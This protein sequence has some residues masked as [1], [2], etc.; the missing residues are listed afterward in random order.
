MFATEVEVIIEDAVCEQRWDLPKTKEMIFKNLTP[1]TADIK[2]VENCYIKILID[3]AR[4]EFEK[5]LVNVI[6]QE[7]KFVEKFTRG[8]DQ[9]STLNDLIGLYK[10]D[11]YM[12]QLELYSNLIDE[13]ELTSLMANLKSYVWKKILDKSEGGNLELNILHNLVVCF[14]TNTASAIHEKLEEFKNNCASQSRTGGYLRKL[15]ENIRIERN[16]NIQLENFL[17][18]IR[19]FKSDLFLLEEQMRQVICF[20]LKPVEIAVRNIGNRSVIEIIGGVIRLSQQLSAI[21][22]KLMNNEH[23]RQNSIGELRFIALHMVEIDCDLENSRWHGFNIFI[24][25]TSVN[26]SKKCQWDLSGLSSQKQLEKA[27]SGNSNSKDGD[28]GIDGHSGESSGNVM[29]VADQMH[30]AEHLTVIVNGG[31]GLNGQ[32]GGD[33]ANGKNGEGISMND[34]KKKFP[35]PVHFWGRCHNLWKV[36]NQIRLMGQPIPSWTKGA[37]CYAELKLENGQEIIHSVSR[38]LAGNCYLLYKGSKGEPGGRGGLN[39][40]GGEGGFSGECVAISRQNKHF[41]VNVKVMK[42]SNGKDGKTGRTGEYGKNGWDVG[43]TDF[44]NWSSPMEFG[45]NQN[46]RLTMSYSTDSSGR[47]YCGYRYDELGSSMCYA[48]INASTLECRK[49]TESEEF[50]EK[51]KDRQRQQQAV[52]TRKNAL[53]RTAMEKTYGQYFEQSDHLINGIFQTHAEATMNFHLMQRKAKAAFEEV[54]KLKERSRE[55][56]SRYQIYDAEKKSKKTIKKSTTQNNTPREQKK[57]NS[58]SKIVNTSNEDDDV[59]SEMFEEEF[60]E[61]ELETI[62]TTFHT[63]RTNRKV[64]TPMIRRIHKKIALAKFHNLV[65][66]DYLL[67]NESIIHHNILN[68]GKYLKICEETNSHLRWIQDFFDECDG[69]EKIQAAFDDLCHYRI[70]TDAFNT[71]GT[72]FDTLASVNIGDVSLGEFLKNLKMD[73]E[74]RLTEAAKKLSGLEA[75]NPSEWNKLFTVLNF[76]AINGEAT[77][78]L[79]RLVTIYDVKKLKD[80]N[81][82]LIYLFNFFNQLHSLQI[83]N[84]TLAKIVELF[85]FAHGE[86]TSLCARIRKCLRLHQD[87]MEKNKTSMEKVLEAVNFLSQRPFK[88]SW[89]KSNEYPNF[90]ETGNRQREFN[91]DEKLLRKLHDLYVSKQNTT[92]DWHQQVDDE[93]LRICLDNMKSCNSNF[94]PPLLELIA[95]KHQFHLKIYSETDSNQFVC[96][97]EHFNIGKQIEH[98]LCQED[99]TIESLVIDQEFVELDVARKSLVLQFQYQRQDQAYF[100]YEEEHSSDDILI[101]ELCQFFGEQDR[102]ELEN[103]LKKISAQCIGENSVLTSLLYCFMCNGC[104][105]ESS[106][107]FLFVDTVLECWLNFDQDSELFTYLVLSYSQFQLIDQLILIKLENLLRRKLQSK[108][109]LQDLLKIITDRCVKI[110]LA[111]RLEESELLIDEESFSNVLNMLQYIGNDLSFLK[112]LSLSDW[113]SILKDSYWQHILTTRGLQFDDTNLQQCSFYLIKLES[114]FSTTLVNSLV[115]ILQEA[116]HFSAKTLLTF[117]HRFYA[118]DVELSEDIITDFGILNTT[119]SDLYPEGCHQY[120]GKELL[121]LCQQN[122]N[123]IKKDLGAIMHLMT[124]LGLSESKDRNIEDIVEMMRTSSRQDDVIEHLSKIRDLL[125]KL[126]NNENPVLRAAVDYTNNYHLSRDASDYHLTKV[127]YDTCSDNEDN[128]KRIVHAIRSQIKDVKKVENYDFYLL[129]IV[130]RAIMLKRGF[131][132]RDTQKVVIMLALLNERNL[133]AQV[134]TGEGK[135]LII[136]TICIIKYLYGEKLDIVTSC[137][138][139]AKRDAESE[140]PK[141]NIDLYT[142]FGVNVGHICSEDIGQRT[143]VFNNCDVIYGDLSSFQRD[144][145]LDRFYGKNI[146]GTRVFKNVIVDEVDSMLLDNGNNM[147]YLSHDIPNMDKLQS[148]YIFLWQ[149]VNRPIKSMEDLQNV[150]DNSAIK[151]SVIADLYGMVMHDDVSDDVWK[152]LIE[153]KT[154]SQDGRLLVNL[155]DISRFV[156][157]LEFPKQKTENR[158]IFLLNNIVTRK[159]SIKIPEDLYNFVERHLDKFIDNAKHALFMSEGVDYVID[160]DRTGLDPDLNPK[161]IIIDKNTGTDQ[162]SSQWHEALHQFLQI[163]HGCK[164]ALMSLKAVFISNVSYFLKLYGNLYGLSGT[165]GSIQEKELLSELYNV[166]LIKIPTSKPKNFFEERPIICPFKEQ[167]TNSIYAETKKKILKRRSVLI[168]GESVKDVEYITKHLIKSANEDGENNPSNEL[169]YSLQKPYVYKRE[170][171]EFLFGQGNEFLSCGKVIVATNLAGRGTDIKLKQGL[172]EAGGLHVI[173]TFLPDN[174]RVEEQAYGRAARCGEQGSGQLIIIDS[175]EDGGSYSSKIF[176]LKSARD[177]NEL[178]RLKTVKKFYDERITIEEDCFKQFKQRYEE[179]RRQLETHDYM[180]EIKRF[181]LD[182]FLDK[183]AFWLDQN[184]QLIENQATDRSKKELLFGKL[185]RFLQPISLNLDSWLDSPSQ[186]LKLGNHYAK[187]NQYATAKIYFDKIFQNHSYYLA[188]AL[189]YS[190]AINIKQ[191]RC[192]LLDKNGFQFQKLKLDLIKAR[193]LFQERINDCMN[194]QAVVESFKKKETNIL[195]HIEAFSEQQKTVSQIYNL[196]INSIN[197]ILGHPV[198][199]S[200]LVTFELHEIL[201]YDA[202]IELQKQGIITQQQTADTYSNDTLKDIAVEYRILPIE[203]EKLKNLLRIYPTVTSQSVA[204]VVN[205]PSLEEFWS[206]LKERDILINEIEFTMINKQKLSQ[207]QPKAIETFIRNNELDIGLTKLKAGELLQYPTGIKEDTI[208]C[209]TR[210]YQELHISTKNYLENR[211]ICSINRKA[212]IDSNEIQNEHLFSKFD[213]I[214]LSDLVNENI[215]SDDG[216]MILEILSQEN[217]GVLEERSNGNYKLK[218]HIDCS[219]LPSCY[220]DVVAAIL[221]STFAYR[222]A[223]MHLQEYFKEIK[224]TSKSESPLT[225]HFRLTS[226]P[227]QQ[228]IFDLI[229]KSVIEDTQVQYGKLKFANFKEIFKNMEATYAQHFE[230]LNKEENYEYINKTLNQLCCGI[231]KLETPDCFYSPLEDALKMQQNSSIVEASWFSLN[232]MEHLITLQ[233]QKYSWKFWRNVLIITGFALAQIVA[234]A[235]IEIYTVGIGTYAASFLIN[236]GISDLFFVMGSLSTGHMSSYWEHK[237]WSMAMTAVTCGVG[238]YLSRGTKVSRIGYKVAGPVRTEGGKKIAEMTGKK[239]AEH[240]GTGTIAKETLKRVGCKLVEGVAY[241]FAQSGVD[242][243]VINHLHGMCTAIQKTVVADLEELFQNHKLNETVLQAFNTMGETQARLLINQVTIECFEKT[244]MFATLCAHFSH[245]SNSISRGFAECTRKISKTGGKTPGSQVLS[246]LAQIQ[247][248]LKYN[249]I[250]QELCEIK[251]AAETF[252]E[253]AN[254]LILDARVEQQPTLVKDTSVN[255]QQRIKVFRDQ[256]ME[257]WKQT[258]IEKSNQG[259]ANQLIA[260]MLSQGAN[261]LIGFLGNSIKKTY[262][263][264]KEDQYQQEFESAKKQFDE[265]VKDDKLDAEK[266]QEELKTYHKAIVKLLSK[267]RD[268]KLFASILREN[269]PMDMTCVQACSHVVHQCMSQIKTIDGEKQFTGIRIIVENT[270]G[271][272]HEYSSSE[273]PSHTITLALDNNHF[274]ITA[275]KNVESSKN[276]CLYESFIEQIPALQTV[277][278]NGT[279]FRE[280]LS[281]YIEHNEELRYT[282]SQGWHKFAIEKGS[283]GGAIK[284]D[285]YKQDVLYARQVV[286]VGN[287]LETIYKN[288]E[289]LSEEV[290]E[291][292]KKCLDKIDNLATFGVASGDVAEEINKVVNEF[293]IWLNGQQLNQNE[294]QLK[295]ELKRTISLFGERV[296]QTVHTNYRT[297]LEDFLSKARQADSS[298]KD[299]VAVHVAD[300]VKF[301]RDDIQLELLVTEGTKLRNDPDIIASAIHAQVNQNL[302]ENDRRFNT[303]AVGFHKETIYVAF[304]QLGV[305]KDGKKTYV[306]DT[307]EC[308]KICKMLADK[309]FLTGRYKVIFLEGKSKPTTQEQCRA[310]HAEMQIMNYWKKVG[311]LQEDNPMTRNRKPRKI[312]AS[313]PPCLCCSVAMKTRNVDHKIY[314]KACTSPK[315]WTPSSAIVVDVTIKFKVQSDLHQ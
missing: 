288:N 196:F 202:L 2:L 264:Y 188:E 161:I 200:A 262:R 23:Q 173:V 32:D 263:S 167:W 232:G 259:I 138:V 130:N 87:F 6:C 285:N 225:F 169:Y 306:V 159:R 261:Q 183:W 40:L 170:H 187:N 34:L 299:P 106:E 59:W 201:A 246:V 297:T 46:Q 203:L 271:S 42:G 28:D 206:M 3:C 309:K 70:S 255:S 88:A 228:L 57:A 269:V 268:A 244:S 293:N 280:H 301:A 45:V 305:T 137:S 289:H 29:I 292:V 81:D 281:D 205:L 139:L 270:D 91:I 127:T 72:K 121:T 178:Q 193:E 160:V 247:K 95:W 66:N 16:S 24:M 36:Y 186:Y 213:S 30:N 83:A 119:L 133:L 166:D 94:Y 13:Y 291:V 304:N 197:D 308:K 129:D 250:L 97:Q 109:A 73:D 112:Q 207:I 210:F 209:S 165:L 144:Y 274:N 287:A 89:R 242:H 114:L 140:P 238:A 216:I 279:A 146:L 143:Q 252:L 182:S 44:Q 116:K 93:I 164:L 256:T 43:Y 35:S 222:L 136:T 31:G 39:G 71:V 272:S 275:T 135:T 311:I 190:S 9:I 168:I 113:S 126:A 245:L 58:L 212:N 76:F 236:E 68:T 219:S 26:V 118:E 156:K 265:R 50:R 12:T 84:K 15:M 67:T 234:G 86:S 198:S 253:N 105:L 233:E 74:E 241:G 48:T 107:V 158:L 240:I 47:V 296:V 49:L 41:P 286:D 80:D 180:K 310:P 181:L 176:Q 276:N 54:E 100:P 294:Q 184:S 102:D 300:R 273:N 141:G 69:N 211:G 62:A 266:R 290:R 60:T 103:H 64:V 4:L 56:V 230:H 267:T 208:I 55:K 243:L 223:Y 82:L 218:S 155:K 199:H 25:T 63:Y 61:D 51:S 19:I 227:Y 149:S 284:E 254:K 195:I 131:G 65:R 172:V 85:I 258:V 307:E 110:L 123:I 79:K 145:L 14:Q 96:I 185:R 148:L 191:A 217:V 278:S 17:R 303:V 1:H 117:V 134:A 92:L 122:K 229:D 220:Q 11:F 175:D 53:Q 204:E 124:K 150:Y 251:K 108:P 162:S 101:H 312:G 249:N 260:P 313:K 174:C 224:S 151:R 98:L 315:N 231:E 189:Y 8:V 248:I 77:Q 128:L 18:S 171:E 104:H 214:A 21:E 132:L 226:N 179:L 125:A 237:K 90:I 52:A 282:I 147:L 163:K 235:V 298:P 20:Y 239:L 99:H 33:G 78:Q 152:V 277:F 111:K 153:S 302:P 215:S 221:N 192:A 37:N 22:Q 27:R 7:N 314:G 157:Q 115:A 120:S 38:Y 194:D 295:T 154:I 10:A 142:L 75:G 177:A 5:Q 283:Y 257:H